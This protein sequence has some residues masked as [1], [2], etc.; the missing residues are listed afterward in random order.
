VR[1]FLVDLVDW[2]FEHDPES[3]NRFSDMIMLSQEAGARMRPG[4]L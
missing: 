2:F 1:R 4:G 3:G